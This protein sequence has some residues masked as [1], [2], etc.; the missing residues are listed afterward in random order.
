MFSHDFIDI[1]IRSMYPRSS[2]EDHEHIK[3]PYAQAPIHPGQ[4]PYMDWYRLIRQMAIYRLNMDS[5]FSR[6][7]P[8]ISQ[9]ALLLL[10]SGKM[11]QKLT[12]LS[13]TDKD[14]FLLNIPY[15][16]M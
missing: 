7:F 2:D 5:H 11:F 8:P 10:G 1:E 16:P 6:K 12:S 4:W 13:L 15:Y 9:H 14:F 3:H